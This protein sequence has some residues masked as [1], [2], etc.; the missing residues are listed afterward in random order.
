MSG[1]IALT[2]ALRNNL[3]TLQNTQ[4][5]IDRT[6][7]RLATGREVNSALDGPQAFFT[8]QSLN[9]RAG[10]LSRLLDGIGQSIRTI[11][12]ANNGITALTDLVEQ[13]DSMATQART[14]LSAVSNSA[15]ATSNISELTDLDPGEELVG[16]VTG[17]GVGDIFSIRAGD[18]GTDDVDFTLTATTTL[19]SLVAEI[20][21]RA[22]ADDLSF[23]ASVVNNQL[24]IS[25]TDGSRLILEDEN[26]AF[27]DDV[28]IL[29]AG[30]TTQTQLTGEGLVIDLTSTA[31]DI[32]A[33]TTI[34]DLTEFAGF[35]TTS[36][37]L[38]LNV[39]GGTTV[40]ILSSA[41][42]GTT[43][44]ADFI[45]NI[46]AAAIEGG[47]AEGLTASFDEV[48]SRIIITADETVDSFTFD[49]ED[50]ATVDIGQGQSLSG[51]ALSFLNSDG[52]S[53]DTLTNL[54]TQ[55]DDI[56]AQIDDIVADANFLGTN[57]LN[58]DDLVTTFNEDGSS[59]LTTEG[60]TFTS[61]GLGVRAA[62]FSNSTSI[63]ESSD[64][65]AAALDTIRQFGSNISND[66]SI[67]Q[68]RQEFTEL[69]I[70]TLEAGADDLTL[71]DQNE[72]GANLLALQT[73][74]QLGVT[75]LSLASQSQQA[76]LS[77]F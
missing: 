42:P 59:T 74:Q 20:N 52:S 17:A 1:D 7:N 28:G 3:L 30:E 50:G 19:N 13:A 14:A 5:L 72:E 47:N 60:V 27:L 37:I 45:D 41:T 73:R 56:R 49:A 22:T 51:T 71:A 36:D 39:D 70:N 35:A 62:D 48:N 31:G 75:A 53:D 12:G 43:S 16:N 67:I 64:Q 55:F 61:D 40:E 4:S 58:G 26:N 18:E 69:T 10:D 77:L 65:V 24:S 33:Q 66:L 32:T 9:N 76:V 34:A 57:L 25:T 8:A 23:E 68:T 2:S 38:N 11:E 29:E 63:Q 54:Q 15:T 44:I 21:D 6:Q 46:N